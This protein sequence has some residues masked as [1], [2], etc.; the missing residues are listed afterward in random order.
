MT[1]DDKRAS[2]VPKGQ[3]IAK[4]EFAMHMLDDTVTPGV[5]HR[6]GDNDRH[7][8]DEIQ[9]EGHKPHIPDGTYLARFIGHDTAILFGMRA[10]KVFLRFEIC[11]GPY[12][13]TRLFRPYRVRRVTKSGPN[14]KFVLDAGSDLYRMLVRVLDVRMRLDRASFRGLRRMV[15]NITT[16]TIKKD[17][18][19]RALG[20][21]SYY[22]IVKEI[23]DGR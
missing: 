10:H 1:R 19:N 6:D 16:A 9:V 14:G 12:S 8:D 2:L 7:D 17:R 11:E 5:V 13:G 23:E 21:G 15:F 4:G 20:S 22:S 3:R 18:E